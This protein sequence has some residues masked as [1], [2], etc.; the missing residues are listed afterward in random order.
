MT[1]KDRIAIVLTLLWIMGVFLLNTL[2]LNLMV[3]VIGCFPLFCYWSIRFIKGNISFLGY[4]N[5]KSED[6]KN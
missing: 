1:K 4:S 6:D 5:G 2:E 3:T